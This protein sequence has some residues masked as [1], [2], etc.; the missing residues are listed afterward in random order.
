MS[1]FMEEYYHWEDEKCKNDT[2][3]YGHR[4]IISC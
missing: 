3:K 1:E 4:M 2:E